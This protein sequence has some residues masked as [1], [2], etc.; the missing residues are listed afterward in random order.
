MRA[1]HL[2][3]AVAGAG[4]ALGAQ[5]PLAAGVGRFAQMN[6]PRL[7]REVPADIGGVLVEMFAQRA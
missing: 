6:R 5:R 2:M 4:I 7:T 1:G 3:S